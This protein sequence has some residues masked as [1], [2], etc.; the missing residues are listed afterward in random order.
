MLLLNEKGE[1]DGKDKIS[2]DQQVQRR[3]SSATGLTWGKFSPS[4]FI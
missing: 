4:K 1:M 3:L 2:F